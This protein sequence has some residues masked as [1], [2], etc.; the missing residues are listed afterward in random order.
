MRYETEMSHR[1]WA[2]VPRPPLAGGVEKGQAGGGSAAGRWAGPSCV[3]TPQPS[4]L[5]GLANPHF[6]FSSPQS[7]MT[8]GSLTFPSPPDPMASIFFTTS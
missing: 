8:T 6:S 1:Q 3:W 4:T 7:S 2:D 5:R